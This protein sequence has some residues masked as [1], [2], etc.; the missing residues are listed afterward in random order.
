MQIVH[1]INVNPTI[2]TGTTKDSVVSQIRNMFRLATITCSSRFGYGIATDD[3]VVAY[4]LEK[5]RPVKTQ[6]KRAVFAGDK[7]NIRKTKIKERGHWVGRAYTFD[8]KQLQMV[9]LKIQQKTR[10]FKIVD[11]KG[12]EMSIQDY[13]RIY[14]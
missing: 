8:I 5:R 13:K 2:K 4:I 14:G 10:T 11:S 9:G 12:N 1:R 3:K 7:G 6:S